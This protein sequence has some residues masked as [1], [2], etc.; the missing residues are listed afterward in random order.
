MHRVNTTGVLACVKEHPVQ[1]IRS[2]HTR[3]AA[4]LLLSVPRLTTDF[5]R[6]QFSYAAPVIWNSLPTEVMLCD[7]EHSFKT[8]LKTSLFNTCKQTT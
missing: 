3:L 8:H 4:S 2:R 5:A 1:R 7:S 6:H